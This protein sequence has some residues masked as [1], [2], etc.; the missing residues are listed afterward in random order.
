MEVL[1]LC[2]H[3]LISVTSIALNAFGF[4]CLHK[5]SGRNPNQEVLLQNLSLTE[6]V[7]VTYD[8]ICLTVYHFHPSWYYSH[9]VYLDVIEV[10]YNRFILSTSKVSDLY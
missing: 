5:Q 6:I 1:L 2:C 8:L 4:Y 9:F 10:R 3:S 7:K